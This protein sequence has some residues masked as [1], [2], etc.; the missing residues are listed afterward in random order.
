MAAPAIAQQF[1]VHGLLRVSV[2][3]RLPAKLQQVMHH[4]AEFVDQRDGDRPPDLLLRDYAAAPPFA[5]PEVVSDAYRYGGRWLDLPAH[6]VRVD[7][8]GRPITMYSDRMVLPVNLLVHL[9]LLRRGFS[10][11]HAAGV[12]FEGRRYLFP[13][14]GGVG[15]TALA[16][17][18]VFAGGKL[19]GDDM[20]IVG[21]EEILAY[22][23]DF[24]VY[25]HHL[26][27]LRIEDRAIDRAFR[28]T[29]ALDRITRWLERWDARPVK[30]A[31]V[32]LNS[33]KV[34]C[35][36]VAPRRIFGDQCFAA[37]GT[38]DAVYYL[39]R[40]AEEAV[41]ITIAPADPVR[42]AQVCT[43]I[44]LYE[45]QQALPLLHLYSALS[46]FSVEE[47]TART[48]GALELLFSGCP[49]FRAAIPASLSLADY[50]ASLRRGLRHGAGSAPRR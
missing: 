25:P 33:L 43:D 13:A 6:R 48:K 34:P 29:A 24:S 46:E 42:L 27:L 50:P 20:T 32:A 17:D 4:L 45:W 5:E 2:E 10:L 31:R 44:L 28:R 41:G 18:L 3:S 16:A 22:P 40:T 39:A 7:L 30:L 47:M 35:V 14:L 8:D 11:V 26:A 36:N 19:Y 12:E 15:K 49:C 38:V 1:D 9:A 37:R 23:L 21:S